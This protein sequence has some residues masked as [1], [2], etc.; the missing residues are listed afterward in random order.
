MAT[1]ILGQTAVR[2]AKLEV[3]TELPEIGKKNQIYLVPNKSSVSGDAYDEYIWI[4]NT[5]EF[6]GNKRLELTID[7]NL[8]PDSANPV[9]NSAIYWRF[10]GVDKTVTQHTADI[11][12]LVK[13]ISVKS[14]TW[15]EI[16]QLRDAGHFST[17]AR[18]SE[19]KTAT[20]WS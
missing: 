14:V 16:K 8:E 19:A 15:A 7:S 11:R 5:W 17:A 6:L 2:A 9:E 4:N 3:V 13:A 12:A 20:I 10:L 18:A 1:S